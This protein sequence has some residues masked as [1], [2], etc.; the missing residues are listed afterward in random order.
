MD[1]RRRESAYP[2]A[3]PT[4]R[5]ELVYTGRAGNTLGLLYREFQN[6]MARPAFSQQLQYDITNDPVI[7]Y[8]GARF[9]VLGADNTSITYEVLAH[10]DL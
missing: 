2:G 3:E 5:R 4:F 6:D 9:K 1:G 8:K 10:L 7:G